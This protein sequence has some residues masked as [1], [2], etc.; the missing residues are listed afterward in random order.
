V[1][2]ASSHAFQLAALN[3]WLLAV[4]SWYKLLLVGASLLFVVAAIN[5]WLLAVITCYQLLAN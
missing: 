3:C 2:L 5:C 1:L 4:I